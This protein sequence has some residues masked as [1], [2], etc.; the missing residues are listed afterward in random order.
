MTDTTLRTFDSGAVPSARVTLSITGTTANAFRDIVTVMAN[1]TTTQLTSTIG[2]ANPLT[3]LTDS[4]GHVEVL[5]ATMR[6]LWLISGG[7][8][9]STILGPVN[10]AI[11]SAN[12]L[13][14][15]A[16]GTAGNAIVA[17]I[18]CRTGAVQSSA[19]LASAGRDPA[20]YS[21]SGAHLS[22]DAKAGVA[23]MDVNRP[24][25]A[26]PN[27]TALFRSGY[28]RGSNVLTCP[29]CV[30]L[31]PSGTFTMT[32]LVSIAART[33]GAIITSNLLATGDVNV[34]GGASGNVHVYG[35]TM[36]LGTST[37]QSSSYALYFGSTTRFFGDIL[38]SASMGGI[39]LNACCVESS[40][41]AQNNVPTFLIVDGNP[42]AINK[43]M[44][45]IVYPPSSGDRLGMAI[46]TV[47]GNGNISTLRTYTSN[48]P[49]GG[50]AFSTAKG[51]DANGFTHYSDWM[52]CT[53]RVPTDAWASGRP[54]PRPISTSQATR[55]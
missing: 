54:R 29:N 45:G 9:G 23:L 10:A 35:G 16:Y 2:N 39:T 22:Y 38:A 50:L 21:I 24:V 7:T 51:V 33:A 5:S 34:V 32:S 31:S 42:P 25:G 8:D 17:T 14:F 30:T 43:P 1:G 36:T 18:N 41:N 47:P 52:G 6:T 11:A 27:L 55:C 15:S 49:G 13:R 44:L 20:G 12:G 46:G 3:V 19:Y 37:N 40:F 26:D 4:N 53:S 48:I 28:T